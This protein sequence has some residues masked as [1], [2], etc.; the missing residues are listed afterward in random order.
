MTRGRPKTFD[1]T[2]ALQAAMEVFWK[3]GYEDA[4]CDEL[5]AAMGIN[6]GSMYST[7]GDKRA[8]FEK[9]FDLYVETVISQ[10]LAILHSTESPIENVRKL[11]GCWGEFMSD[12]DCKGCFLGTVLMEFGAKGGPVAE[13]ARALVARMQAA[14]EEQLTKAH[15]LGEIRG[16]LNPKDMA[17]FLVN[18]VQG[19]S[20]IS[21][22][23]VGTESIQGVIRTTLLMLN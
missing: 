11:V 10:G 3:R 22:T 16:D 12:P 23:K 17:A 14:L 4:S 13:K 21:R 15:Q 7:F 20:V 6:C 2:Q 5:L 18:T 1:E 19:L 9:A 8:L